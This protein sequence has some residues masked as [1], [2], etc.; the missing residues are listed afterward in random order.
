MIANDFNCERDLIA[1]AVNDE[2][3]LAKVCTELTA[4][5]FKDLSKFFSCINEMYQSGKKVDTVSLWTTYKDIFT[6]MDVGLNYVEVVTLKQFDDKGIAAMID[7]LKDLSRKREIIKTMVD[8]KAALN[9][10]KKSD[11]IMGMLEEAVIRNTATGM[12]RVHIAPKELADCCLEAMTAR[13]DQEKREKKVINT[14]FAWL[15]KI[16]GGF[17]KSDL[18]II[19]GESGG[20]KSA[21]CMNI[22]QDVGIKQKRCTAYINSE[23]S[24]DQMALRLNAMQASVSH[25]KM[26]NGT[27]SKDE[28][29]R[30]M[31]QLDAIHDGKLHLLTIPDLTITNILSEIRRCKRVNNVE[32]VIVDYIGRMDMSKN[33]ER[34]DW[35]L[36]KSAAQKL[37]TLA[38][39]LQIVVIMVS[40]VN[41]SGE[42][43]Q[44]GYMKHEADLWL[45]LNA[46]D[47]DDLKKYAPWNVFCEIKKARNSKKVK[48]LRFR[49]EGDILTF[50]DDK[51]VANKCYG[52]L[53]SESANSSDNEPTNFESFAKAP[54]GKYRR[55]T[56]RS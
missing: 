13:L 45:N 16:T 53:T 30:I 42:L 36:L 3:I 49:F 12:E 6:K 44:G 41:G 40:Q 56:Y 26:R 1:L 31:Q 8:V 14:R 47:D 43:A 20:G 18:I 27:I 9:D 10:N 11:E 39:E 54:T 19:S 34:K 52:E 17:E 55:K 22:A 51:E 15:N 2:K 37:K 29:M 5:D 28:Q 46:V 25:E 21:F 35:E 50:I 24:T 4:G 33:T 23:M 48:D 7:R 32:M 38:Q